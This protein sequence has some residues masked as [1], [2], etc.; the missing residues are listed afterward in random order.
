MN[1]LLKLLFIY[2]KL[3]DVKLK[4]FSE[5]KKSLMLKLQQEQLTNI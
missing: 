5:I 3:K 1:N 2:H 4:K